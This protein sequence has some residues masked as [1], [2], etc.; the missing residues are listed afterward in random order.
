MKEVILTKDNFDE[1]ISQETP[2]F[3]DFWASWCGPCRRMSTVIEQLAEESDGSYRVGTLNVDDERDIAM[4]YGIMNIPTIILFKNGED[5]KRTMG[6]VN[7]R[8]LL[9]MLE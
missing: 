7:I 5:T 1:Q 4:R 2:M 9:N 6:V 3:V 8:A